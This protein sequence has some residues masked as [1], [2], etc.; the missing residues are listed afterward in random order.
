MNEIRVTAEYISKPSN[1]FDALLAE[2]KAAKALAEATEAEKQPLIDAMGEAK[3]ELIKKQ[4]HEIA[5]KLFV[6]VHITGRGCEVKVEKMVNRYNYKASVSVDQNYTIRIYLGGYDIDTSR[7]WCQW[8]FSEDGIVT[9]WNELKLYD[10]ILKECEQRMTSLIDEQ[11]KKIER[12][13][14]TFNNMQNC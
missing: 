2:F 11:N 3:L 10:M 5:K 9:K 14:N 6:I 12:I 7:K 4:L 13:N 8:W 1:K